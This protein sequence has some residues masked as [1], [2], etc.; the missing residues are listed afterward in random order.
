[1]RRDAGSHLAGWALVWGAVGAGR[2]AAAARRRSRGPTRLAHATPA[3]IQALTD[4]DPGLWRD[5]ALLTCAHQRPALAHIARRQA[6]SARTRL[7]ALLRDAADRTNPDRPI[8]INQTELA[9]IVG[10][11]RQRLNRLLAGFSA[12][13][14]VRTDYGAVRVLSLERLRAVAE[15]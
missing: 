13:G 7:A 9:A 4:A 12:E 11:S 6:P 2:R 8:R 5:L 14:L 1:R 10:V 3:A 15:G